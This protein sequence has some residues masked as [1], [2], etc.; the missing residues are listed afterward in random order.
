MNNFV[1]LIVGFMTGIGLV[2]DAEASMGLAP[3]PPPPPFRTRLVVI[4][5]FIIMPA[6]E[7]DDEDDDADAAESMTRFGGMLVD[8]RDVEGGGI[9][10]KNGL[11]EC[12]GCLE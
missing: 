6:A 4:P 3:P 10:K 1:Y 8:G 2:R 9:K 7:D 12:E 5:P 11:W